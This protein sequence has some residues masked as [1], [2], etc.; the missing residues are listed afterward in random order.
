[1]LPFSTAGP[2]SLL[3]TATFVV[4]YL[5]AVARAGDA[6]YGY[7]DY[8]NLLPLPNH[9]TNGTTLLVLPAKLNWTWSGP[10]AEPEVLAAATRRYDAI[11]FAWGAPTVQ[12][13]RGAA[14]LEQ[15]DISVDDT[16][17]SF[18]TLQLGMDESYTMEVPTTGAATIRAPTVWGALRALETLAQMIEYHPD[19]TPMGALGNTMAMPWGSQVDARHQKEYTLAW[20]P[21]HIADAPRFKHRGIMLDTARH[22]FT[23]PG[24]LRQFD[25]MAA[26]KVK[27][28]SCCLISAR[29]AARTA[30]AHADTPRALSPPPPPPSPCVCR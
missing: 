2:G 3:L 23:V 9:H 20:A 8:I 16:D 30:T 21:W 18:A 17:D 12:P 25:A 13:P 1:M 29:A 15:V 24:I 28:C 6:H 5:A 19:G 7:D 10:G 27:S 4:G 11:I 26:A 22:F 14:C